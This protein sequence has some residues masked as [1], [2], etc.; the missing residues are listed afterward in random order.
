MWLFMIFIESDDFFCTLCRI[1][2]R[3]GWVGVH[4]Q[5][6]LL[7]FISVLITHIS[8]DIPLLYSLSNRLCVCVCVQWE[9]S[10]WD[11]FHSL[12]NYLYD[13]DPLLNNILSLFFSFLKKRLLLASTNVKNSS[14]NSPSIHKS[15]VQ[16]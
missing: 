1:H 3:L 10:Y 14:N 6:H 4:S 15:T 8:I 12:I 5:Y 11:A 7:F 16:V 13:Q 9:C 2:K